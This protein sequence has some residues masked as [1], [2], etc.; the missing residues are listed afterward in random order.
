MTD[1]V[2]RY[3]AKRTAFDRW[4]LVAGSTDGIEQ[5]VAIPAL[6]EYP[7]LF[8]TLDDLAA[9]DAEALGRT[10]V[11]CVVNNR[12]VP[13]VSAENIENN[14]E[15]LRRLAER[16]QCDAAL[17]LGCVDAA[18]PGREL[19]ERE[20]V[21][22]AR[23]IGMDWG[24]A[25]L[26]RNG[27]PDG[28][29]IALD[30]DTRVDPEYLSATQTFFAGGSRWA[31]V[32]DYA[33]PL[34][35]PAAEVSAIVCYELFLRY[36]EL[37]LAYAT[38][39]Y[40]FPT[41][42]SAM[43]C[44]GRAYAAV[45]GMNRRQ[46]GEDFYFLQQLAKTG[47]VERIPGT[48]VRPSSR[49]SHRVPFGTGAR[50]NEFLEGTEDTYRVY[51]PVGYGIIKAWLAAV[52]ADH[53]AP[54]EALLRRAENTEPALSAFLQ[55]QGFGEVWPRFQAQ[56]RD[57]A[58]LMRHFHGWFDGFRTLKLIHHLRNHGYPEQDMFDAIPALLSAMDRR[59]G[60]DAEKASRNDLGAQQA[61]LTHLRTECRKT[62]LWG[63]RPVQSRSTMSCAEKKASRP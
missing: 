33:H 32:L 42:G 24:L 55:A 19:P 53:D 1:A 46:A 16:M 5:V 8:D 9:N 41:I 48:T 47:P 23:K 38:S 51:H 15:T 14:R 12:A 27:V 40:A 6:A 11:I 7:A 54:A 59:A 4:P 61:L 57:I 31:A 28:G 22:L 13:H 56:H 44:T 29:L 39:P 35:G 3:L 37:G 62:R 43:A 36:H 58:Q 20:G 30:A 49:A 21:G 50:V 17:R 45:S 52:S 60:G 18:S 25:V 2:G 63:C 26:Y 10:L 34:E